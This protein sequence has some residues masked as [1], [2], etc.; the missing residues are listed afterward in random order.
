MST[1][2][3]LRHKYPLDLTGLSQNNRVT[4]ETHVVDV[5]K[6]TIF[7]KEG[8]FFTKNFVIRLG[9]RTLVRNQDYKFFAL[10]TDASVESNDEVCSAVTF[11]NARIRGT[12]TIEYNVVGGRYIITEQNT[13]QILDILNLDDR[14]VKWEHISNKPTLYHPACH[15]HHASDIFGLGPMVQYLG[16]IH[17]AIQ[18]LRLQ[19]NTGIWKQ[20]AYMY[21][22]QNEFIAKVDGKIGPLVTTLEDFKVRFTGENIPVRKADYDIKVGEIE[23]SINSLDG[24]LS[25]RITPLETATRA[26]RTEL[27]AEKRKIATNTNKV[28]AVENKLLPTNNQYQLQYNGSRDA[29]MTL[30]RLDNLGWKITYND[31]PL[32]S[33]LETKINELTDGQNTLNNH[34]TRIDGRIDVE[35]GR[36]DTLVPKVNSIDV[37]KRDLT[38]LQQTVTQ[39]NSNQSQALQNAK[40]ELEGRINDVNNTLIKFRDRD[41]EGLV[42]P[43]ISGTVTPI[44]TSIESHQ[45]EIDSLKSRANTLERTVN[46]LSTSASGV[47][48]QIN[49]AINAAKA[50]RVREVD[51]LLRPINNAIATINNT[52]VPNL[53]SRID[54]VNTALQ[55]F[56]NTTSGQNIDAK[57]VA[58]RDEFVK[59]EDNKIRQQLRTLRTDYEGSVG[60]I[61]SNIDNL[62]SDIG[63]VKTTVDEIGGWVSE[64]DRTLNT[65]IDG[66]IKAY[67]DRIIVPR[68]TAVNQSITELNNVVEENFSQVSTELAG[69]ST[70]IDAKVDPKITDVFN[71]AK[72]EDRKLEEWV[73]LSRSDRAFPYTVDN[74]STQ[75]WKDSTVGSFGLNNHGTIPDAGTMRVSAITSGGTFRH[76]VDYLIP[77]HSEQW[78]HLSTDIA[79]EDGNVNGDLWFGVFAFDRNKRELRF[80]PLVKRDSSVPPTTWQTLKGI[81]KMPY[82][83][84]NETPEG[85]NTLPIGTSYIK[86]GFRV[87]NGSRTGDPWLNFTPPRVRVIDPP[88]DLENIPGLNDKI[89]SVVNVMVREQQNL[90]ESSRWDLSRFRI[91]P[92][93]EAFS[94]VT[95]DANDNL[96]IRGIVMYDT[97][98]TGD[99]GIFAPTN[100]I[101]V[102][103]TQT[104]NVP[105]IY[106]GRL[107]KIVVR[108]N[109]KVSGTSLIVSAV[110][111]MFVKLEGGTAINITLGDISSFGTYLTVSN[112]IDYPDAVYPRVTIPSSGNNATNLKA[113]VTITV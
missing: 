35:K 110:R 75:Q 102:T 86:P 89:R 57:I 28:S 82:A 56:I 47:S 2:D 51:E 25:G 39:N 14:K 97:A 19:N 20:I 106:N 5:N 113:L 8:A 41:L 58:F 38:A 64:K 11:I 29:Y 23:G 112:G 27:D 80:V 70:L 32:L 55:T 72:A 67:D 98:G 85:E 46:N 111:E 66:R 3:N 36:I 12:I 4:N 90:P 83:T 91:Q 95:T 22:R 79:V 54:G 108:A 43:M 74:S 21:N 34:V 76:T 42:T 40:T 10:H 99:R 48:S 37:V 15:V 93:A 30:E 62:R 18:N 44:R 49:E 24:R 69:I 53:N 17:E 33:T 60:T 31:P 13:A 52:T 100:T 78:F 63:T 101:H 26:L 103:E 9:N 81:L 84:P 7:P 96:N 6:R 61:N 45:L 92:G 1:P 87:V 59:V 109:A 88:L 68:I 65:D 73:K 16:L 77:V 50:V 94:S 105:Q 71:R 107:A 104:W